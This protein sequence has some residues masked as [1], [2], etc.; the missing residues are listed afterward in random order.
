MLD[1]EKPK[2]PRGRPP[3]TVIPQDFSETPVEQLTQYGRK[4]LVLQL[5]V[6]GVS[7]REIAE[8]V[9][10]KTHYV[11]S[12]LRSELRRVKKCTGKTV[13]AYREL[14]LRR[15]DEYTKRLWPQIT[16]ENEDG[17]P[18]HYRPGGTGVARAI[19]VALKVSER[20][21]KLLGL[22]APVIS[23][24]FSATAELDTLTASELE[25]EAARLGLTIPDMKQLDYSLPGETV[26]EGRD[27]DVEKIHTDVSSDEP[28]TTPEEKRLGD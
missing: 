6:R 8:R 19:E 5:L 18:Y 12:I 26:I 27:E 1:E 3:G 15:L 13:E 14:E 21:A 25:A 16:G 23:A 9:G 2:R 28:L 22:D 7:H 24:Q 17:T 20:R 10:I 4:R 11:Y